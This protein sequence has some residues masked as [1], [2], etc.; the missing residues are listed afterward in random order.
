MNYSMVLYAGW[1]IA[2]MTLPQQELD[3]RIDNPKIDMAGFLR[4]SGE[5]AEHRET[6][7]ISE[8]D[9]I[10]MS[11]EPDTIIFDS[12]VGA[13]AGGEFGP[14]GCLT[15]GGD[16]QATPARYFGLC[17]AEVLTEQVPRLHPIA[18]HR[19]LRLGFLQTE[20]NLKHARETVNVVLR[21]NDHHRHA[22]KRSAHSRMFSGQFP[23]VA[24][25]K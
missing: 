19:N 18:R 15:G 24:G 22:G 21:R 8:D 20:Y 2:G 3:S 12:A 4:I 25:W 7:R 1:I 13:P 6:R 14:A 16:G 9:F 23:G 10:R 17:G 5:A 11:R